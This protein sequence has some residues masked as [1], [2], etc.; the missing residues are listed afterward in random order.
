MNKALFLDRDGVINVDHGYTFESENFDF[1]PG[2]F[3]LCRRFQEAGYLIIV[4]TN[5]SGIARKYYTTEQFL[6]LT[7]W[8]KQ[9][10]K[11]Q[12]V[13]ITDVYFCPHHPDYSD[14]PCDCRKPAP[15]MLLQAIAEHQLD[16][17]QSVMIGDKLSDAE[18]AM[19]AGVGRR[20][21][22]L[23]SE[24]ESSIAH[25]DVEQVNELRLINVD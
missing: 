23:S 3:D 16:P 5:Q 6:S 9:R 4:V 2:I 13:N 14:A 7:E 25:T 22:F 21:L 12:G 8:M 18:A 11:E 1:M 10:F 20:V 24:C 15:G 17:S 19:R